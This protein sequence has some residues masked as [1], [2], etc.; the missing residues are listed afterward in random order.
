MQLKYLLIPSVITIIFLIILHI[1]VIHN[2]YKTKHENNLLEKKSKSVD[3]LNTA[4]LHEEVNFRREAQDELQLSE[5]K[6]ASAFQ[7]NS[8]PMMI[9]TVNNHTLT[10]VN[11]S[12]LRLFGLKADEVTGSSLDQLNIIHD[13]D[14]NINV[15]TKLDKEGSLRNYEVMIKTNDH[16]K[17][18]TLLSVDK[19]DINDATYYLASIKDISEYKIMELERKTFQINMLSNS[20]L[21]TLGEMSSGIAYEIEQPLANINS[22]INSLITCAKTTDGLLSNTIVRQLEEIT[23]YSQKISKIL[24]HLI[25]FGS[26]SGIKPVD[27]SLQ[28]IL[29]DT[30]L[31]M[32]ERIKM[33]GIDLNILIQDNLPLIHANPNKLEQVFI[34]LITNSIEALKDRENPQITI[35]INYY[36]NGKSIS[37]KIMDN[38]I[39][40]KKIC[41]DKIFEPFYTT[42]TSGNGNGFGLAISYGIINEHLGTIYCE[43]E[44]NLGTT[45]TIHLPIS[46]KT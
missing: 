10:D 31:L 22:T 44:Y 37:I 1:K 42:K 18:Y 14:E 11:T 5:A 32:Q 40:I 41:L 23:I 16:K 46:E 4:I 17:I 26:Q 29:N 43:S 20:K 13:H 36:P 25:A 21:T 7:H 30:L 3:Q 6:F 15:L 34:N 2:M 38:G 39:G 33:E 19:I 27:S 24:N 12:F 45:F 9:F 8:N 35:S 28:K